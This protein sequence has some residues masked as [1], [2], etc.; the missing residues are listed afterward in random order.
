[1]GFCFSFVYITIAEA[2]EYVIKTHDID[3]VSNEIDIKIIDHIPNTSVYL[4]E[5]DETEESLSR[6]SFIETVEKNNAIQLPV[7]EDTFHVFEIAEDWGFEHLRLASLAYGN[8]PV[9]IALLDTGVDLDHPL[10]LPYLDEGYTLYPEEGI[11]DLHGHGTGVAGIIVNQSPTY[12]RIVP[13]K[14]MNQTGRGSI[15]SVVNGLYQAIDANVDIVNLSLGW[16]QSSSILEEAIEA[17][18]DANIVIVAAVGN[19]GSNGASYPARYSRVIGVGSLDKNG[20]ISSFSQHGEGVD[21]YVPGRDVLTTALNGGVAHKSGTSFAAG[22]VTKAVAFLKTHDNLSNGEI[23]KRFNNSLIYQNQIPQLSIGKL[24]YQALS[25]EEQFIHKQLSLESI[26]DAQKE[27]TI[28]F[29]KSVNPTSITPRSIYIKGEKEIIET[30]TDVNGSVVTIKPKEPLNRGNTY[31]LI[32]TQ[33]VKSSED[34]KLNESVL[35]RFSV[36]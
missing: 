36:E 5:T 35:K 26:D 29:S 10:L 14:V 12:V 34:E 16:E 21:V 33:Y 32:V 17:A 6:L 13:I 9:R 19:S 28:V 24:N 15:Y 11:D 27:W 2:E 20:K 31:V 30:I 7:P 18:Y 23:L 25:Y 22:Y 8:Q 1:M 4:I 3:A